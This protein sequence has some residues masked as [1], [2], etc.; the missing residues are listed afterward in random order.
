VAAVA[1]ARKL[2]AHVWQP[3]FTPMALDQPRHR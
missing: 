3:R 1:I 2:V